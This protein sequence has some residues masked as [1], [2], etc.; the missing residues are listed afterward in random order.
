MR[1]LI[2]LL[3]VLLL[4][5]CTKSN[6]ESSTRKVRLEIAARLF[7]I[8]STGDKGTSYKTERLS[9][10]TSVNENHSFEAKR[11]E[12]IT[13]QYSVVSPGL[14]NVYVDN[15]MIKSITIGNSS[16]PDRTYTDTYQYTIE[17]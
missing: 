7:I 10:L 8:Q 9:G 17:N 14:I 1:Y 2:P 11:G 3:S 4:T 5:A 12:T 16:E 15:S 6:N 13:M